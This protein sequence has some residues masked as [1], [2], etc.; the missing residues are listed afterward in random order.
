[1]IDE[2]TRRFLRGAIRT[3]WAL[4]ALLVL[5]RAAPR[6]FT[7]EALT[8][9][10]RASTTLVGDILAQFRGHGIV[11]D[12]GAEGVSYRPADPET[13]RLIELLEQEYL[14]RPTAVIREILTAPNERI[15]S[16]ADAFK[17]TGKPRKD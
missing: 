14:E 4:D 12:H 10:L 11:A 13:E 9:E 6:R 2:P 15:Q 7:V 5:K 16:F 8:A 17:F 1:M 3:V